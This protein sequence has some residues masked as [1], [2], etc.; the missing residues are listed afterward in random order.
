MGWENEM[1]WIGLPWGWG[2]SAPA[3]WLPP[4]AG[5]E[6]PTAS[7]TFNSPIPLL[8]GSH[9]V[10]GDRFLFYNV[11]KLNFRISHESPL[12]FGSWNFCLTCSAA[13]AA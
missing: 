4:K 5:R 13:V 1:I 7:A 8:L 10:D 9:L 11:T 6:A 12:M 3:A 2:G